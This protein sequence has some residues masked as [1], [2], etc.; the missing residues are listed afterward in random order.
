MELSKPVKR[1]V[2]DDLKSVVPK[3]KTKLIKAID[4]AKTEGEVIKACLDDWGF[5]FTLWKPW[6]KEIEQ[7]VVEARQPTKS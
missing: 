3:N 5:N 6:Q 2:L 1:E 4:E 7:K